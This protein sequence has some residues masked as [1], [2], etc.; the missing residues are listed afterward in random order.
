MTDAFIRTYLSGHSAAPSTCSIPWS[1]YPRTN[2]WKYC[3]TSTVMH[4]WQHRQPAL[5]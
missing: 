3:C 4:V 2:Y 1:S 5:V